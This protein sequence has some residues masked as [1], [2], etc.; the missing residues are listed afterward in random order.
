MESTKTRSV[1]SQNDIPLIKDALLFYK[2]YKDFGEDKEKMSDQIGK[3]YHR[4]GRL[5]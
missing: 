2:T 1:F 4:L 5:T 3:L